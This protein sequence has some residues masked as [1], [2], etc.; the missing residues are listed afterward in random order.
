M[1]FLQALP[2]SIL[3]KC[4]KRPTIGAK[5]TYYV[6]DLQALPTSSDA[7]RRLVTPSSSTPTAPEPL[8]PLDSTFPSFNPA[9][10]LGSRGVVDR[11]VVDRRAS[12][13]ADVSHEIC[14]NVKGE[15]FVVWGVWFLGQK[16]GLDL[17]ALFWSSVAREMFCRDRSITRELEASGS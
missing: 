8:K 3:N 7:A 13:P 10:E 2:T 11:G 16:V 5:E 14:C 9:R 4:Q 6:R 12:G 1:M 17:G 15:G